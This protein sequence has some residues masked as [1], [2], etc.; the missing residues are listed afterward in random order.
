MSIHVYSV[1][2]SVLVIVAYFVLG[3]GTQTDVNAMNKTYDINMSI[4]DSKENDLAEDRFVAEKREEIRSQEQSRMDMMQQKSFNIVHKDTIVKSDRARKKPQARSCHSFTNKRISESENTKETESKYEKK[5]TIMRKKRAQLEKELGVNLSDYGYT[6]YE[7]PKAE[8]AQ[9]VTEDEVIEEKSGS[10]GFYGLESETDD[11]EG[12]VRAVVHGDHKNMKAGSIIKLRLLENLV[13]DGVTVPRNT[14]VYGKLSFG[15]GRG[16][17]KIQNINYRNKI[18][19]FK[20]TVYDSD[21]FEGI[22]VPENIVSDTKN[23]AASAAID[24][25]DVKVGSKSKIINSTISSLGN[26]I[27]NAVQ[28]SIKESKIS[29]SSNYSVTIKRVK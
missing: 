28:G 26:V 11:F 27:K 5:S 7:T 8:V 1:F 9:V 4:P 3:G 2:A 20:G 16:T 14:F 15:N 12:D 21:G 17:I 6:K 24:G 10:R 23:K 29:I 22:Y 18:L 19:Q 25:V 13:V